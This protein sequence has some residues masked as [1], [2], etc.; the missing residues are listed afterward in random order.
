MACIHREPAG[1]G[2]G[3]HD[4]F[5]AQVEHTRAFA[6][7]NPQRAQDERGGHAQC[8]DPERGVGEDVEQFG[9]A[10]AP[11]WFALFLIAKKA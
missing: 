7:Q 5:N 3:H 10:A 1:K 2:P 6:Q 9:H 4:P 8:G 11:V